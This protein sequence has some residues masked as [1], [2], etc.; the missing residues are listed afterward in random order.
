MQ[1]SLANSLINANGTLMQGAKANIVSVYDRSFLY[2]DS[3]YEV[4]RTYN[5]F[6][7]GMKEHLDRLW[8]T[9]ELC[10]MQFSQSREEL[11]REILKA[12]DAFRTQNNGVDVYCR[13]VMSRGVGRIG[14]GLKNLTTP[15]HYYIIVQSIE[16]FP[17]PAIEQGLR[18]Q[19]VERIRNHPQA[20]DP[21]MKSGNYL[22]NLLAFLEAQEAGYDDALMCTHEGFLTEGTT[23]NLFYIKRGI[24]VTAPLPL[25]MLDG[26]TRRLLIEHLDERN[27]PFRE[28]HYKKENLYEA[29]EVFITSSLKEVYPV[30]QVDRHQKKT[31]PLT[32]DLRTTFHQKVMA[33]CQV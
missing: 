20:L 17:S 13:I 11:E 1:T 3:L 18:L 7:F 26:I 8:K 27:I 9:A 12:V 5:G 28:V 10:K 19:V 30:T 25:G 4:F 33:L 24:V 14:F 22:N 31:G 32:L 6:P 16:D 21:A 23:F 29:D 15:T 2:G